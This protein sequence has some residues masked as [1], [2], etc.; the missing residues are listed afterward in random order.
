MTD[1][2][3]STERLS[4]LL[5]RLLPRSLRRDFGDD[6][7]QL[8]QDRCRHGGEPLWRL[9]PS[10]V[11]D[12]SSTAV[13]LRWEEAM[14]VFP[15]R[16]VLIGVAFS[17]SVL[18]VLSGDPL[19]AVPIIAVAAFGAYRTRPIGPADPDGPSAVAWA[20]GGLALCAVAAFIVGVFSDHD[21]APIEWF[22]FIVSMLLGLV[23]IGAGAVLAIDRRGRPRAAEPEPVSP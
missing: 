11:A 6:M 5:V 4:R 8:A 2:E 18:A 7:V 17:I 15:T 20:L 16:A 1:R 19:V 13:R 12:A 22:G 10:L 9:W 21:L 14:Y 23:G 3:R